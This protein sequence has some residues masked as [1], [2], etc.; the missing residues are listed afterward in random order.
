MIAGIVQEREEH[1][2]YTSFS[3]FIKRTQGLHLNRQALDSLISC[4]ALDNLGVNRRQMHENQDLL[5]ERYRNAGNAIVAGQMDL[6]SGMQA[7]SANTEDALPFAPEFSAEALLRMEHD[8]LGFYLSGHPLDHVQW[9]A[10]LFHAKHAAAL[11]ELPDASQVLL[12][13]TV[14]QIKQ[15]VTKQ[16]DVMCFL[17][18]EDRT[19]QADC[20]VFP[21]LYPVVRQKLHPDAVLCVRGRISQKEESVS[22]LCDSLLTEEEMQRTFAQWHLCIKLHSGDQAAV[23]QALNWAQEHRGTVPL[24]FYLT[25]QKRMLMLKKKMTVAV[26]EASVRQLQTHFTSSQIGMIEKNR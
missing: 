3:D 18:C 20:V 21:K 4:G 6:F 14:Q 10:E 1:G 11:R 23:Q 12:F 22:V 15:H 13:V 5:L 25:D 19:G 9:M 26:S 7:Q 8:S 16:G 17:T 2:R 24:C